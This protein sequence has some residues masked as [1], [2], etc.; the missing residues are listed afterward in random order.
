MQA[1]VSLGNVNYFSL[2]N[3]SLI[4]LNSFYRVV[5]TQEHQICPVVTIQFDWV[6]TETAQSW[7]HMPSHKGNTENS[8]LHNLVSLCEEIL[9]TCIS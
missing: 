8:A 2:L 6:V 7:I 3:I 1:V 5:R 4:S 9:Q